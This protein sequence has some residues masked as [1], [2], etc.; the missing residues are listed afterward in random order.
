MKKYYNLMDIVKRE[1]ENLINNLL[2]LILITNDT[3]NEGIEDILN[4]NKDVL[5]VITTNEKG[6]IKIEGISNLDIIDKYDNI[7]NIRYR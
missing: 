3:L 2:S 4:S 1:E 5:A 6:I 7:L